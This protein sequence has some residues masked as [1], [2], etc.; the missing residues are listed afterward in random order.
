MTTTNDAIE[1]TMNLL[2]ELETKDAVM[3]A[4][5]VMIRAMVIAGDRGHGKEAVRMLR[6]VMTMSG[7]DVSREQ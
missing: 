2:A 4:F 5:T 3:V 6:D 7:V 1:E